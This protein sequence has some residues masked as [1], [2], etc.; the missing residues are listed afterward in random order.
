MNEI[1]WK[2]E[3]RVT[4]GDGKILSETAKLKGCRSIDLKIRPGQTHGPKNVKYLG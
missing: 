1:S 2:I 4:I 3:S